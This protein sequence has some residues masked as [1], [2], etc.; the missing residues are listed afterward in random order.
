MPKVQLYVP[1]GGY[2]AERWS[3]GSSMPPLGL[4]SI[5]A[6]LEKEGIPVEIVPANVL[7]LGWKDIEAKI[8]RDKPDIVGVTIT[9]ENR[10]QSFR[11]IRL[12]KKAHS[13]CLTVLG[14]PHASMAAEDCLEHIAELDVVVRGEG[15]F[16]MLDIGRAWDARPSMASLG[17]IP[18]TVVRKNG[19]AVAG[20]P[21]PRSWIWTACHSPP[22][23]WSLLINTASPSRSRDRAPSPRST[24]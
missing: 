21:G 13:G 14:G 18:G 1:P 17:D 20:P 16:T 19:R 9:T 5:G 23:T 7:G 4:L 2:F 6:V 24:S 8:R 15:E 22:S 11:M 12:A 3:K 10:F